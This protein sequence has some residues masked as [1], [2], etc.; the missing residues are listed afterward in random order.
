MEAPGVEYKVIII[1]G[2]LLLHDSNQIYKSS[3]KSQQFS[4]HS[5]L[6]IAI[7]NVVLST[8]QSNTD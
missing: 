4:D 5:D 1:G 3:L 7:F 2:N 6:N 8:Y